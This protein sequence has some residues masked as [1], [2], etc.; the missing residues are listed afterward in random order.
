[1]LD[2]RKRK[3]DKIT[4]LLAQAFISCI[5]AFLMTLI[6]S[7]LIPGFQEGFTPGWPREWLTRYITAWPIAFVLS[8]GVGPIAF[9]LSH[10]VMGRLM[11]E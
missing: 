8:L 2:D 4:I 1:M 11:P 6:V 7:E 3:K 10:A 5:M 9:F